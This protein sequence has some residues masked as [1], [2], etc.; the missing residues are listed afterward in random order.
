[1]PAKLTLS[2]PTLP[3]DSLVLVTGCNGLI[4]SHAADQLLAAGYRVRGTVRNKTKCSYLKALYTSRHGPG[5]FELVEIPDVSAPDA[6][7]SAVKDVAAIATVVGGGKLDMQDADA[8][9]A[10]ELPWQINLLEAARREGDSVKSFV[11]TSSAWAAYTP[12]PKRGKVTLTEDTWNDE[13]VELSRD[14][15]IPPQ[16]KGMAGFMA[17]KT[18]VE[19]GVWEW[20]KRENP[21]FTF[22]TILLDTVMGE[23][24]DPRNQGIPSTAGMV[25][26]VW[27]GTRTDV[28]DMMEPQWQVDCRDAGK[29]YV[30]LLAAPDGVDRKRVF[31]F[32]ERYSWFEVAKVLGEMYPERRQQMGKPMD[33]GQDQSEVL[34]RAEAEELLRRV[35]QNKGWTSLEDSLRE[36]AKSW[37]KL[38]NK[39]GGVKD[40]VSHY[41]FFG[42]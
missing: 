23:C 8:E 31:A 26:W 37:L 1:M 20:V 10:Q 5:R 32:G 4:A 14:K 9:A 38:E 40:D 3:P 25:H 29:L 12:D 30:A 41:S 11:F 7:T 27:E 17:F 24:L 35:G 2:N 6:W 13:A 39:N 19:R 18:L 15:S 42:N 34:P 16:E 28:L 21:P 22:N 33:K 36:N